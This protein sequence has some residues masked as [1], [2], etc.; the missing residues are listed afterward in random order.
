MSP[1]YNTSQYIARYRN[2]RYMKSYYD[3]KSPST[4]DDSATLLW[5]KLEADRYQR[6]LLLKEKYLLLEN[7]SF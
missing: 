6:V 2:Y 7:K 1:T 4:E 3:A 5:R